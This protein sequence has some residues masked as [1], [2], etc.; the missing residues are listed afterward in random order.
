MK[1]LRCECR[2]RSSP[3]IL[4]RS[5]ALDDWKK[6]PS[7]LGGTK[8]TC[9]LGQLEQPRKEEMEGYLYPLPKCSHCCFLGADDPVQD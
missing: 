3:S 5:R 7:N 1:L 4:Q 9:V 6:R 8:L 2:S